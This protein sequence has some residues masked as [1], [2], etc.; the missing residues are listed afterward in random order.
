MN[1]HQILNVLKLF[2]CSEL[3]HEGNS[4]GVGVSPLVEHHLQVGFSIEFLTKLQ[5]IAQQGSQA[6]KSSAQ[7]RWPSQDHRLWV[8]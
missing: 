6:G 3:L 2:Y 1:F 7:R 5:V 4:V 8:Q